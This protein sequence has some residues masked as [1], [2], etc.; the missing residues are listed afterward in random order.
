MVDW[1]DQF[2]FWVYKGERLLLLLNLFSSLFC[3][4]KSNPN[5]LTLKGQ[6]SSRTKRWS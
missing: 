6:F 3:Q 1:F 4:T 5:W 2:G